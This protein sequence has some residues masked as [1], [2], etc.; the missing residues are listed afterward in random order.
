MH[1]KRLLTVGLLAFVAVSVIAAIARDFSAPDAVAPSGT[2]AKDTA[3]PDD[4]FAGDD[5]MVAVYFHGNTRCK[6][7]RT[8]ESYA[9][10]AVAE[11]PADATPIQPAYEWKVVNYESAGYEHFADDF[12][13]IA[14]AV[15]L[16]SVKDGKVAKWENLTRVWELVLAGDQQAFIDYVQEQTRLFGES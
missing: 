2:T 9:H 10:Q 4:P 3:V 8:I 11:A 1:A 6:T 14:P 5:R 7:C 16:V 13:L 15:V 12:Q